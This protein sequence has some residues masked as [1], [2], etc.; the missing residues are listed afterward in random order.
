LADVALAMGV[1]G[2]AGA[3][4]KALA[5]KLLEKFTAAK[6]A[7]HALNALTDTIKDG[8]KTGAKGA[9]ASA[10]SR[11][12]GLSHYEHFFEDQTL[13]LSVVA[14]RN[15]VAVN[16]AEAWLE[17]LESANPAFAR[18]AMRDIADSIET[19]AQ[20]ARLEQRYAT[21]AQWMSGLARI[22]SGTRQAGTLEHGD[23]ALATDSGRALVGQ[24]LD[25]KH[26]YF[27]EPVTRGMLRL[28]V[29]MNGQ[30]DDVPSSFEVVRAEVKG[31][32]HSIAADLRDADLRT[33][34]IP[35]CLVLK[36]AENGRIVRDEFG[37][38][39]TAMGEYDDKRQAQ[40]H[41]AAKA[42]VA[43]VLEN[44]LRVIVQTEDVTHYPLEP[45]SSII[46]S[47]EKKP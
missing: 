17:D 19:H 26:A 41:R 21:L 29:R 36:G 40:R 35:I 16:K 43:R 42:L 47:I 18:K 3:V 33:F 24:H 6:P 2:I 8:I 31:V 4:G 45:I 7:D 44:P 28:D 15:S 34:P 27:G 46:S 5:G 14:H 10:S 32:A 38:I 25:K 20:T 37:A 1:G 11:G 9:V 13:A 22:D 30:L 39:S 12:G 23:P